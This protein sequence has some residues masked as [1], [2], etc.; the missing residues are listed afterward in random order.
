[1]FILFTKQIYM[2]QNIQEC[3]KK[4]LRKTTLI[5]GDIVCLSRPYHFKFFKGRL[6]QMLLGPFLNILSKM[7][8]SPILTFRRPKGRNYWPKCFSLCTFLIAQ[9][10]NQFSFKCKG[11]KNKQWFQLIVS[12]YHKT[13]KIVRIKSSLCVLASVFRFFGK[14]SRQLSYG[15]FLSSIIFNYNCSEVYL[16]RQ[17]YC[18]KVFFWDMNHCQSRKWQ[19]VFIFC[20]YF[21]WYFQNRCTKINSTG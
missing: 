11:K 20:F 18:S 19:C 1:M 6:P 8:F 21:R 15:Y 3:T 16:L 12:R 14:S 2:R 5:W 9:L 7:C 13:N 17:W 10:C 4:N